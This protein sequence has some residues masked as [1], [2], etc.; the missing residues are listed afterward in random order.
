MA[1]RSA[2]KICEDRSSGSRYMIADRQADTQTDRQA[3]CNT[4]LL[5]LG[6]V[7]AV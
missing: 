4:P 7:I 2:Q 5:C 1:T 3:D 6:T